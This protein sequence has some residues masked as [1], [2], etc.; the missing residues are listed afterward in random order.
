MPGPWQTMA[1]VIFTDDPRIE[2]SAF[3]SRMLFVWYALYRLSTSEES[4]REEYVTYRIF[5]S[6]ISALCEYIPRSGYDSSDLS[7]V[8]DKPLLIDDSINNLA[9]YISTSFITPTQKDYLEYY[10]EYK[11]PYLDFFEEVLGGTTSKKRKFQR[12][13]Y[14][15]IL[16]SVFDAPRLFPAKFYLYRGTNNRDEFGDSNQFTSHALLST[17]TSRKLADNFLGPRIKC[18]TLVIHYPASFPYLGI[19][20]LSKKWWEYEILLPPGVTFRLIRKDGRYL[21]CEAIAYRDIDDMKRISARRSSSSG[22]RVR[23]Q[24]TV[25]RSRSRSSGSIQAKR[26]KKKQRKAD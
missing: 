11:A 21:V 16:K 9:S 6:A 4:A 23:R 17:S 22:R 8:F 19:A 15:N 10:V 1:D 25:K 5:H 26:K 20:S 12:R 24:T 2:N 14:Q 7:F 13:Q 3:V 18:C